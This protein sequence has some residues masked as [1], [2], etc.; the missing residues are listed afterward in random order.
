MALRI[1]I[2]SV[3]VM[4]LVALTAS[5]FGWPLERAVY[6]APVIVVCAAA[7][8][9]LLI[10]WVRSRSTRCA[11]PAGPGSS[12]ACGSAGSPFVVLL[13]GPGRRA[14]TRGVTPSGSRGAVR[15]ADGY[16][17]SLRHVRSTRRSE[18]AIRS[19]SWPRHSPLS[20]PL[21]LCLQVRTRRA[22]PAVRRHALEAHDLSMPV[23][24][25]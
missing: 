8:I 23:R 4:A 16:S 17:C 24:A 15:Q 18:N 11:R 3:A 2:V 25:R 19:C 1:G 10:L 7:M 5:I 13:S 20:P 9:G 12:S 22:R 21:S 14:A 6:L